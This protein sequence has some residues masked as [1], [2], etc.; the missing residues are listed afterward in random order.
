MVPQNG[1]R[2]RVKASTIKSTWLPK[3][4]FRLDCSPYLGGA[5]E[6]EILLEELPVRKDSLGS[7]TS[8]IFNGPKFSRTFVDD[9]EHGV[10]FIG[11]SDLQK[12][13]LEEL[14]LLSRSQAYG[15]QL[16]HLEIREGMTLITCSGTIGKM[17]YA[18]QEL[19]GIWSS[20][21]IMKVVPD[22]DVIRSGYL[23][24]FL[25]S[26]FGVPLV[27][28]GTYGSIIQS[29]EPHHISGLSIPRFGDAT[30]EK[31]H[32]LIEDSGRLRSQASELKKKAVRRFESACGIGPAMPP[33]SYPRP[34]YGR[35]TS[36]MMDARMDATFY[37]P[38]CTDAREAFDHSG[39]N[40]AIGEV[41]RVFIPGIFKR[42]YSEDPNFGYPYIT[43]ADVF[44]IRPQSNQFLMKGVAEK[45]DLVLERG[46]ILIHEAGQ[47]YGL[48]GRSVMVGD[49]LAGFSCTNNM[50]RV[51][52]KNPDEAGYIYTVLS[53]E[54]GIRLLKR[55]AAGSSIPHLDEGR[56]SRLKIPWPSSAI[57]NEISG[58]MHQARS[59]WD[60]ADKSEEA[61]LELLS[62]A[63]LNH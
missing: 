37:V 47:R 59:N 31:I 49:T 46:M 22:P 29:I 55:E 14:P 41:A 12:A 23:Y 36:R 51:F 19:E 30:E 48:I 6:T 4:G 9:P 26:R 39:T 34:L 54:F 62:N 13:D 27:V 42:Q 15:K 53:S 38:P 52:P 57:R 33:R 61:A 21:H 7:V 11:G 44:C 10:R 43:G 18:R 3:G 60:L 8:A 2:C 63:I 56:V 35:A 40:R 25:S 16:R 45:Y 1:R 32:Q 50:V 17:A 28:A 5:I 24:A 20:Q 58:V